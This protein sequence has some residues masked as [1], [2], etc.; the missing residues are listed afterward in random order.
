[1]NPSEIPQKPMIS[2]VAP[3]Y[4]EG[5][6]IHKFYE[7][8]RDTMDR[9]GEP[10]ELVMVN[11]GSR[12]NSLEQMRLIHE[13]DPRVR[14]LDFAR[15]FGHQIAVTAGMDYASG[16]AVVI[17]DSDLQDPPETIADLVQKWREGY[18]VVYAVRRKRPGETWFKLM[19]AKL[20]YRTIYRI[21]EI[22]IPLDTG[23]FRLMDRRVVNAINN[24]REHNRFIRGMTSWVGFRQAGVLYD[25]HAREWGKT[26]YPLRKM[27]KLAWD[28]VTGFS[29]FPLRIAMYASFWLF[30]LSVLGIPIV[31]LLRLATGIQFFEG[32]ATSIVVILLLS[33]FQFFFFFVMGQYLGR[34]YDEVRGRPLYIVADTF[35]IQR[36]NGERHR[37]PQPPPVDMQ[38]EDG[39]K[40]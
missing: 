8:V 12:D 39:S 24:M 13:R 27:I 38:G 31:S 6:G 15:N 2:I 30:I 29:F 16:D 23:D 18:E 32:Q 10:W 7:R 4:N 14:L 34:I 5:E 20:F 11:D 17:I 1:M 19:T 35:G 22:D 36:Q 21:T 28:A 26:N 9:I 25:R 3:V 33:S 40:G 37:A